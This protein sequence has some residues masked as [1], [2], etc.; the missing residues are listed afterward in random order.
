MHLHIS[1]C[2]GTVHQVFIRV[3][4]KTIR[5]QIT[6]G[7]GTDGSHANVARTIEI[8]VEVGIGGLY[9]HRKVG[10]R[11]TDTAYR[12]PVKAAGSYSNRI[13]AIAR[14]SRRAC[15]LATVGRPACQSN[16]TIGY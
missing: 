14:R 10:M 4:W 5:F 6:T 15:K 9:G 3:V 12:L 8:A 13:V 11:V 16:I 7:R 2:E 1:S